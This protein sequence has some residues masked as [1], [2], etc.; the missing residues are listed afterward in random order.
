MEEVVNLQFF[1]E[2]IHGNMFANFFVKFTM[3]IFLKFATLKKKFELWQPDYFFNDCKRLE[4][5][6]SFTHLK[7]EHSG[8][9]DL[10][11]NFCTKKW[12]PVAATEITVVVTAFFSVYLI[13]RFLLKL[14]HFF[15]YSQNLLFTEY[16]SELT[17]SYINQVS[18][19]RNH[20]LNNY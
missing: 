19:Y 1:F 16:K 10:K 5:L 18:K 12:I 13:Q 8:M 20:N 6:R 15:M 4:T 14:Y 17:E 7:C 11:K 3:E 2:R 9:V